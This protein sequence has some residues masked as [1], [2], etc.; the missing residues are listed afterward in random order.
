MLARELQ[1]Q[2]AAQETLAI[3][4]SIAQTFTA[5][6]TS[7]ATAAAIS[8]GT[9]NITTATEG[10]GAIMPTALNPADSLVVCNSTA[11]DVYV[12][13]GVGFSFNGGTANIPIMLAPKAARN[14]I[15]IDGNNFIVD[16]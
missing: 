2:F 16:Q 11:V 3:V 8:S 7:Q 12:Y 5:A 15:C 10:Q 13:P 1:S 9:T 6:G 4:G 14:F